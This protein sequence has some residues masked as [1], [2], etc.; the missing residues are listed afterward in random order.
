MATTFRTML[1][2]GH[3]GTSAIG[4]L[5]GSLAGPTYANYESTL[6]HY[7]ALCVEEGLNPLQATPASMVRY[8]AW[9]GLL[10]TFAAISMQPYVSAV[11]KYF[12]DHLLPQSLFAACSPTHDA[13]WR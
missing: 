5:S 7:F 1:G 4:M 3:L 6:R 8:T 9:L 2:Y 10:G 11:N 12:R 13:G